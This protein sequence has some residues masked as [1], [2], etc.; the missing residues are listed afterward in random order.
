MTWENPQPIL[1]SMLQNYYNNYKSIYVVLFLFMA[2]NLTAQKNENYLLVGTYTTGIA[3][4]IYVYKFNSISEKI[5]SVSMVKINNPS[6]LA[7][8]S[9]GKFVYAVNETAKEGNGGNITSFFYN[10]K[11]GEL[12]F[13][14]EQL[15]G[16]DHP[17]HVRIDKTG[18]WI[19]VSNYSSGSFSVFP[20]K[21]DGSIGA[22]SS[23]T[24]HK[25]SSINTERQKSPH[26]HSA[27]FSD[28]NK[29]LFVIDLGTD[30]IMKYSFD[31]K[32]G[33]VGKKVAEAIPVKP[34]AGPR[35]FTFHPNGKYAYLVEELYGS[36]SAYNY[37]KGN[38]RSI[39]NI[40]TLPKGFNG[41]AGS[42]EVLVSPD[43]RFLYASN[44]GVSNTIAIFKI[45]QKSGKLTPAGHQSTLGK[46]PRNFNFDPTGNYLF[47]A[48]QDSD[49]IV[50]FKIDHTTGLLT[51]TGKR[52]HTGKPVCLRW[53][54]VD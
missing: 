38:L 26:V 35:H 29:Y 36:I 39:Q 5:D 47:V 8:S 19:V 16:G 22:I 23:T 44:R 31:E 21:D 9:T 17:C 34:G 15:S 52:I 13:I 10:N 6:F 48:N 33:E 28:D 30:K 41:F 3:K 27:T 12:S 46:A 20:I 40:S 32:T 43:G 49:E 18:K 14:N 50:V 2:V 11:T 24:L 51:D 53:I 37:S 4:G 1:H 7:T 25:G 45:N 42:A 54:P